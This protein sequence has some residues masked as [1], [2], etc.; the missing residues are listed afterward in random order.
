MHS[1]LGFTRY[2]DESN[3][4]RRAYESHVSPTHDQ[5]QWA[6][7]GDSVIDSYR[8]QRKNTLV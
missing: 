6:V 5:Y 2:E 4:D 3:G 1:T 8:H 7:F